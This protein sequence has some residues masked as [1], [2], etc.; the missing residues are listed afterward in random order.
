MHNIEAVMF[1]QLLA[2]AAILGIKSSTCSSYSFFPE[3]AQDI[4]DAVDSGDVVKAKALQ[5]Q[6]SLA[7][8]A[9]VAEGK[10]CVI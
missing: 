8:E 7:V 5:E 2:P 9:I 4:L 3:L 10:E 1:L 6:L